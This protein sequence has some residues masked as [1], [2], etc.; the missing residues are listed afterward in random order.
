M[1]NTPVNEK[2]PYKHSRSMTNFN[3]TQTVLARHGSPLLAKLLNPVEIPRSNHREHSSAGGRHLG[4][5]KKKLSRDNKIKCNSSKIIKEIFPPK[6]LSKNTFTQE[7]NIDENS[8]RNNYFKSCSTKEL[9][10]PSIE[11]N[12]ISISNNAY[13]KQGSNSSSDFEL[14]YVKKDGDDLR[15]S[16]MTKLIYKQIWVPTVKEKD[17]NTLIIFDWDDT[18]LCTSFLTPH[19]VFSDDIIISKQDIE[20]IRKLEKTVY[21]VLNAAIEKGDTF[22][23]TNA[24]PGWVEYSAQRFYPDVYTHLL[25]KVTIVSARGEYEKKY[26]GDMRQ[27]KIKAFLEMLKSLNSNLVTN[28]ICMGDSVI[29]MEAAHILASKFTQAF[30]KTVKFRESPKPEELNKQLNLVVQQFPT[31]FSSVKNLT[32]RVEKKHTEAHEKSASKIDNTIVR[33]A[34]SPTKCRK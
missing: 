6:I 8:E 27:W 10:Q 22:I 16:Y 14:K 19:G 26:P 28:L 4:N 15:R 3:M 12:N 5:K 32:I 24:A 33:R 17:H 18:L 9:Y 1:G 29:E 11:G 2:F 20:R 13:I 21:T 30:I 23:V 31:I 7:D 25:H 34:I